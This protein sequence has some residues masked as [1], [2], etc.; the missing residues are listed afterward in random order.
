MGKLVY[1]YAEDIFSTGA[2][3]A[4]VV[5]SRTIRGPTVFTVGVGDVVPK[6]VAA[7]MLQPALALEEP[8]RIVCMEGKL[9]GLLAELAVHHLDLVLSDRPAPP[10]LS[11][12]AYSHA[13]GESGISFFARADAAR[14]LRRG[15][16]GSLHE[17]PMLLPTS[18]T[19]LRRSLD[20]WFDE[21]EIAPRVVGEFEDSA[22][23]KAF[24]R[25]GHG[26][27][28]AP[29]A[30]GDEIKTQYRVSVVGHTDAIT[31]SFYAI[32]AERRLKHP[33]AAAIRAASHANLAEGLSLGE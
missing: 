25:G 30:I 31:E 26:V 3:L 19:A 6:L 27:F 28:P 11:I 5:R 32:S 24:G 23:L 12:R 15:F 13:L 4:E 7:R 10:G 1:R 17:A 9:E 22:L 21:Q 18:D 2:E 20:Q 29:T 33:A 16:P 14:K 8:V